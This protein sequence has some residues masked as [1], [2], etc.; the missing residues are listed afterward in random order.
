MKAELLTIGNELLIGHTVNT[1]AAYLGRA[2]ASVG[3]LVRRAVTVGD[4]RDE[5]VAA[6]EEAWRRADVLV[7]TGGLG[8]THDDITKKAVA[9]FCGVE[10]E[11]HPE[12]MQKVREAFAR[13]NMEMPAPNEDQAWLPKGAILIDNPIGTAVGLHFRRDGKH[14]FV[15]PGVPSEMRQMTDAYVVPT[16]RE[17]SGGLVFR[18]RVLRTTGI[19]ESALY[20]LLGEPREVESRGVKVAFLPQFAG[21]DIALSVGPLDAATAEKL[22]DEAEAWFRQRVGRWIYGRDDQKLEEVV[23]EL[24][25]KT[26]KTVATAES[27]TGGLLANR[28]TDVSGSSNYF[29]RGVVTYSNAS[30]MQILGVREET[31]AHHGAV[32]EQTAREM[33]EGVRRIS[34]TDFGVSTTGIA[35]PTGGTPEKPVGLVYIGFAGPDGSYVEK[36]QFRKDRLENKF[37]ATQAALAV[38]WRELGRIVREKR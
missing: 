4:E 8:P 28:L 33:A 20:E 27:C 24:F 2:L 29:D 7:T 37:R 23:A 30:K 17:L 15:L 38:L 25:F 14:C 19:A 18:R 13:R 32:S 11:F 36:H 22:L 31:L 12:I 26:G 3:V 16:L 5:I 9:E 35:G 34:G 21:V 6:L 10:L 1:N